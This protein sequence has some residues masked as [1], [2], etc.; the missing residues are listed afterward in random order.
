MVRHMRS[1]VHRLSAPCV[2]IVDDDADA[3][4]LYALWL[5][6]AGHR[7]SIVSDAR[8]ALILAPILRPNV[9]IVDIGLPGI[10][11]IELVGKLRELPELVHCRYLAVTAYSD[12]RLPGRC[13]AAGFSE[14]FEKP[15]PE[16]ALVK[17]VFAGVELGSRASGR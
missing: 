15:F 4:D 3:A 17:S 16:A 12:P 13:H 10:D 9:V 14:F 5:H 1:G 11:G 2:L 8:R 6:G 7:V